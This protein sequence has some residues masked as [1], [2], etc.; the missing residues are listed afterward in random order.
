[1]NQI[2]ATNQLEE[3]KR[4]LSY[5]KLILRNV[6]S[7]HC[8]RKGE[9]QTKIPTAWP[10]YYEAYSL[11]VTKTHGQPVRA[12]IEIIC[13]CYKESSLY[14]LIVCHLIGKV[15]KQCPRRSQVQPIGG[16]F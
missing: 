5:Q 4:R 13:K 10:S 6:C 3:M 14:K 12:S 7:V 9:F 8:Q 16:D 15:I 1:M 11:F 2:T